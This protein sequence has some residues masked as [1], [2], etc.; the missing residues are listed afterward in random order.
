MPKQLIEVSRR[1]QL[2]Y[3][4]E[5][6]AKALP[7]NLEPKRINEV[8]LDVWAAVYDHEERR[9]G[10]GP[11]RIEV[12]IADGTLRW[13]N[14]SEAQARADG[15]APFAAPRREPLQ[16]AAETYVAAKAAR[17]SEAQAQD[18][19]MLAASRAREAF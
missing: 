8:P 16:A 14:Q 10:D 3:R 9:K 19:A 18:T 1:M 15:T 5:P 2:H 7:L 6:G 17:A 4:P 13:L 12:Y 11:N